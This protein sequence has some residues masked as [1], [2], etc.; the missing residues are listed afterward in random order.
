[1]SSSRCYAGPRNRRTCS[2]YRRFQSRRCLE[3][4]KFYETFKN[5]FLFVLTSVISAGTAAMSREH[6]D[7]FREDQQSSDS[8][9][10]TWEGRFIKIF[11]SNFAC[12]NLGRHHRYRWRAF[13]KCQRRHTIH[14]RPRS[15]HIQL[16]VLRGCPIFGFGLMP[17]LLFRY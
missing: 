11:S 14:S 12:T 7:D 1:M 4:M 15:C 10:C 9:Q 2:S 6:I 8:D 3:N 13:R 5:A 17:R 16:S